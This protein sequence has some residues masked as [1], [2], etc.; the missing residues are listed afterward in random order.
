[1]RVR[2]ATTLLGQSETETAALPSRRL[3]GILDKEQTMGDPFE[4]EVEKRALRSKQ[5]FSQLREQMHSL[6]SSHGV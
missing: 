3:S 6:E 4:K 1:M 2:S 5:R